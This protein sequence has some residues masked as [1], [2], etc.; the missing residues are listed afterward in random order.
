MRFY[1]DLDEDEE[2]RKYIKGLIKSQVIS[3]ARDFYND[4][5][6]ETLQK[7]LKEFTESDAFHQAIDDALRRVLSAEILYHHSSKE[8]L[9][10]RAA[11]MLVKEVQVSSFYPEA[12]E[13]AKAAIKTLAKELEKQ[14]L[15]NVGDKDDR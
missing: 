14:L 12:R 13:I 11:S 2:M 7:K 4:T 5:V 3:V 9:M 10:Q 8:E 1:V 6:K 15:K